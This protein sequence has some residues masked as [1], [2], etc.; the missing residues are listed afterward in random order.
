MIKTEFKCS[1]CGGFMNYYPDKEGGDLKSPGRIQCD[2][3]TTC[4]TGENPFGHSGNAK[5]AYEIS[6]QKF[7]H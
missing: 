3:N 4:P 2:N 5:D 6:I 7:R 1:I